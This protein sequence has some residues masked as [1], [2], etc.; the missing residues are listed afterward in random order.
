LDTDCVPSAIEASTTRGFFLLC[1]VCLIRLHHNRTLPVRR[2]DAKVEQWLEEFSRQ[3]TQP[4]PSM[5]G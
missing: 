1:S 5:P 4:V 2:G 3:I